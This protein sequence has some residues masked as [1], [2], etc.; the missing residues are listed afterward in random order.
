MTNQMADNIDLLE[1]YVVQLKNALGGC[2]TNTAKLVRVSQQF[3][4]TRKLK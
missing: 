3:M 4:Y 2:E 1:N